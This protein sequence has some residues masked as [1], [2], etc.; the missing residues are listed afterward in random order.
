LL[1]QIDT[2]FNTF[3]AADAYDGDPVSHAVLKQQ[4]DA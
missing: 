2:P 4:Q 1:D 3:I